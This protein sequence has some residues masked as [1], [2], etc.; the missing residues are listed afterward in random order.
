MVCFG[1]AVVGPPG[2]GKTTY[3]HGM[4]SFLRASGRDAV[5][6]NLDPA[7]DKLP[8]KA[9]LDVFELISVQ[10]SLEDMKMAA[11]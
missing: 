10:V 6:V 5:I 11:Q 2:S 9:D 1:Q 7:N 8:F 4:A 3:C